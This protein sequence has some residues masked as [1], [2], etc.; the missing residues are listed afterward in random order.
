MFSSLAGRGSRGRR[1]SYRMP[2]RDEGRRPPPRR[3]GAPR[4]SHATTLGAG[5]GAGRAR[6]RVRAR[7]LDAARHSLARRGVPGGVRDDLAAD[8]GRAFGARRRPHRASRAAGLERSSDR[9]GLAVS[10]V[11]SRCCGRWR[12][13]CSLASFRSRTSARAD[14]GPRRSCR[15]RS[16]RCARRSGARSRSLAPSRS[17]LRRAPRP[18]RSAS[19]LLVLRDSSSI[20]TPHRHRFLLQPLAQGACAYSELAQ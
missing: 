3:L 13:A 11:R 8:L 14:D 12:A 6:R 9:T 10:D 7:L 17:A 1:R 2:T 20:T 19:A 15:A 18:P 5:G 16:A 4:P